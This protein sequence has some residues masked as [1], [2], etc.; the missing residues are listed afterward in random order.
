M[1]LLQWGGG[2][3]KPFMPLT[4]NIGPRTL[5]ARLGLV[6]SSCGLMEQLSLLNLVVRDGGFYQSCA[7]MSLNPDPH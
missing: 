7:D 4:A 1:L 5:S 2:R 6:I 3:Q